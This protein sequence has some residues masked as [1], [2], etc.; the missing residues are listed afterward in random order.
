MS[1]PIVP[2]LCAWAWRK[3]SWLPVSSVGLLDG[4]LARGLFHVLAPND[5]VN[6]RLFRWQRVSLYQRIRRCGCSAAQHAGPYFLV[7]LLV[8]RRTFA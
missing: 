5:R 7:A 1:S 3:V 8:A 2:G 6:H 4:G